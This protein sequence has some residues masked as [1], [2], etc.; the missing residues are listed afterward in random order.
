MWNDR[1]SNET[2]AYGTEPNDFL[3]AQFGKLPEGRV[4]CLGDGEGRNSVWL[5]QQGRKV[6]AV[7][8][9]EVGLEKARRL[10]ETRGV[11]ITT[12]HADLADFEIKSQ[13]WNVIVSIF[14]HLPPELRRSVHRRCVEGLCSG[15]VMLLE[16][17]T[18]T[19]L[20]YKTGGPP[21]A[22]M[23]MDAES[24]RMDLAGLEFQHL[25][26]CI[27]EVHEG[28][29]HDGIGAVVQAVARKS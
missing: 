19:Q 1:Y 12:V 9:S 20:E 18:P 13:S 15:G 28:E 25:Q 11:E 10:A 24:L 27:R 17:Y 16:A 21:T 4:L 8:A 3:V 6:T 26:E 23:M 2:Y 22:E 7:D 29:F 5:A 14:C